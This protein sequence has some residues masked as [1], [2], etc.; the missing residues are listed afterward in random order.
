MPIVVAI[1]GPSGSGKSSTARKLA[2]R[3]NWNYLD[4]GALYRG[5]TWLALK[6][7][8]TDAAEILKALHANPLRFNS[9]PTQP[10]ITCGKIDISQDIRNEE[11]TEQVSSISALPEIR[12]ELVKLQREII[13]VSKNGIVVEGRDIGTV[14]T[15]NAQLKIYLTAD[16]QARANRR[17][18]R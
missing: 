8:L 10:I 11:V 16:L 6:N 5:I 15:P 1:D 7:N 13:S 18:N 3:A 9:D 17:E 12:N 14:V 4:T 2:I